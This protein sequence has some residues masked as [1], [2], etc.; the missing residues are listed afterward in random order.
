MQYKTIVLEF[1][2]EYHP[3]Q[4][5]Q[6]RK[7]HKLLQTM[8]AYAAYLKTKHNAWMDVLRPARPESE[9]SQISSEALELAMEELQETLRQEF[10][11]DTTEP[12][13]LDAAM[14]FIRRH[15]PPA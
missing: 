7:S 9:P 6:L 1:L 12:L 3:L 13:S 15:T 5:E 8:N 2:Q 10:S 4:H 11:A 14:A